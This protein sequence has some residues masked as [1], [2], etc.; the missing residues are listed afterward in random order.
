MFFNDSSMTSRE[1]KKKKK[2]EQEEKE[3]IDY[4]P[5]ISCYDL[6]HANILL[7]AHFVEMSYIPIKRWFTVKMLT[8]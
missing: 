5:I 7:R 2:N 3:S 4:S 6:V 1:A 8:Y